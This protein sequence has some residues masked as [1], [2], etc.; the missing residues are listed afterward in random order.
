[1]FKILY[2]CS[3]IKQLNMK[4]LLDKEIKIG[5]HVACVYRD[6]GWIIFGVVTDIKRT[7][8][9]ETVSVMIIKD[10]SGHNSHWY[11]S[12]NNII[13]FKQ[14]DDPSMNHYKKII[15][16]PTNIIPV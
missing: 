15:V 12:N 2:N 4:D 13:K 9:M 16:I 11:A 14:Y 10:G 7:E 1:M 3:N 8:K 6:N 5:D